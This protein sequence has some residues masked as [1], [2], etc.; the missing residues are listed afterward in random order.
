[1]ASCDGFLLLDLV[2]AHPNELQRIVLKRGRIN[3]LIHIGYDP[4][5]GR[6]YIEMFDGRVLYASRGQI[7]EEFGGANWALV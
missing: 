2:A 5:D 6:F 4:E 3:H 1:M 7:L